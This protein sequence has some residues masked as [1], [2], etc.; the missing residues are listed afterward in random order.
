MNFE[1]TI[2]VLNIRV[3]K[4]VRFACL[5]LESRGLVFCVDFGTDNAIYKA[6]AMETKRVVS[7]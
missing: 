2:R 3:S 1:R 7:L 5:Y 6:A 4:Q